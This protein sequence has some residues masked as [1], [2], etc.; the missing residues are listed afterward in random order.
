MSS[1]R[2][3]VFEDYYAGALIPLYSRMQQEGFD[4]RWVKPRLPKLWQRLSRWIPREGRAGLYIVACRGKRLTTALHK[5]VFC[6]H[7]VGLEKALE[8]DGEY[9]AIFVV[10]PKWMK[11]YKKILPADSW[12]KL[13]PVGFPPLEELS[14]ES[15]KEKAQSLQCAMSLGD[16]PTVLFGVLAETRRIESALIT[17]AVDVLEK[18]AGA[19]E[20]NV[21]I[22]PNRYSRV[23]G[24]G[25]PRTRYEDLQ[26]RLPESSAVR[27]IHPGE[28]ILPF[29]HISD[30][31][32]S[33][34]CSSI[35][36]EFMVLDKPTIQLAG[37]RSVPITL[38]SPNSMGALGEDD[39]PHFDVGLHC[40]ADELED[41]IKRSLD[42]PGEFSRARNNWIEESVYSPEGTNAR[43]VAAI[44]DLLG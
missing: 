23:W 28:D 3:I 5:T 14:A 4:V 20:V 17:R 24:A 34:R 2:G 33:G 16:R 21:L 25:F 11:E 41:C 43:G 30:V 8:N 15:V 12:H 6:V 22:K 39:M 19:L 10:G 32:I 26:K 18:V 31:L 7:G 27:L 42:N 38:E 40:A 36:T 9:G 37:G 29:Y 44:R 1:G 35:I 13:V